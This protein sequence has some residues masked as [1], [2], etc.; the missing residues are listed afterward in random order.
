MFP[1]Q[2]VIYPSE[3]IQQDRLSILDFL[4]FRLQDFIGRYKIE[5]SQ[6]NFPAKDKTMKPAPFE[7]VAPDTLEAALEA[8]QLYG[9]EA[10]VLAGGQSLIPAMNF[11]VMQPSVLAV[12]LP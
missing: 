1:R 2:V 7:F 6:D 12:T 3:D 8:L 11:R 9:H 10:K 4:L 5:L